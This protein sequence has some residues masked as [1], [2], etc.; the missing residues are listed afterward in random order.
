MAAS[1]RRHGCKLGAEY[2]ETCEWYTDAFYVSASVVSGTTTVAPYASVAHAA[3][4]LTGILVRSRC[5]YS[6]MQQSCLV[7]LFPS[8]H[9][10]K[11]LG[12]FLENRHTHTCHVSTTVRQS[13]LHK[14]MCKLQPSPGQSSPA[15]A[16]PAQPAQLARRPGPARPAYPSQVLTP[17]PCH[18]VP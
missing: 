3:I 1:P 9:P 7:P 18:R 4:A 14:P 8:T 5:I 2:V 12:L 6:D 13:K 11:K 16:S 17:R 15:R 10:E